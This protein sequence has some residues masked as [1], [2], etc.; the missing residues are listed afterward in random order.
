MVKFGN[1]GGE[2]VVNWTVDRFVYHGFNYLLHPINALHG[3]KFQLSCGFIIN[4]DHIVGGI[5]VNTTKILAIV[6]NTMICAAWV[7]HV[8]RRY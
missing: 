8:R 3:Q 1:T 2:N 4:P 6:V 7:S 5:L